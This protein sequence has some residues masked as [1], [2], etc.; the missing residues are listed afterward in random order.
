MPF[1]LRVI[2][3]AV[4]GALAAFLVQKFVLGATNT[5]VTGGVAGAVAAVAV[6]RGRRAKD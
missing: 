3:A 5:A 4:L 1:L 2:V 6:G